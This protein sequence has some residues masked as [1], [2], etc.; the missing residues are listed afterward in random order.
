[1]LRKQEESGEMT[2]LEML[3]QELPKRGGWPEGAVIAWQSIH[4]GEVYFC[5]AD[6]EYTEESNG[7]TKNYFPVSSTRGIEYIVTR[8]QYEAALAAAQPQPQPQWDGDGPPPAGADIEAAQPGQ[9]NW[10]KFKIIAVNSGA[11]FGFWSNGV[12]SVLDGDRWLFRPIRSKRQ[13]A[14][15]ALCDLT[16]NGAKCD[17]STGYGKAWYELYDAIAAGKIPGIKLSD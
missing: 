8:E 3:V 14:V 2:L 9:I 4:D 13:I 11:V 17:E 5:R 15:Q 16:G 1:V 7:G 12:A 6:G 10:E